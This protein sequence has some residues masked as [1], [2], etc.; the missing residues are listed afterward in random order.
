M[1]FTPV[2]RLLQSVNEKFCQI[3]VK[4]LKK[5]LSKKIN[6][7]QGLEY[8]TLR[9]VIRLIRVTRISEWET[10]KEFD[11]LNAIHLFFERLNSV[12]ILY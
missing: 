5:T 3:L 9:D 6:D 1:K 12:N 4:L 8:L 2:S 10:E 7:W 11:I